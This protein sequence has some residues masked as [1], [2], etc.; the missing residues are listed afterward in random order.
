[1]QAHK[2][3]RCHD[4]V[5]SR[6]EHL[7]HVTTGSVRPFEMLKDLISNYEVELLARKRAF[8]HVVIRIIGGL[9]SLEGKFSAPL[10]ARCDFEHIE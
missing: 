9:I 6:T 8:A 2:K 7:V 5:S 3:G 10:G 1:M 4:K